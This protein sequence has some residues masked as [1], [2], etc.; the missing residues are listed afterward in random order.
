MR[1]FNFFF[2]F[3]QKNAFSSPHL[4]HSMPQGA[5]KL[6]FLLQNPD[7]FASVSFSGLEEDPIPC[8][9]VVDGIGPCL[10]LQA[11]APVLDDGG[12]VLACEPF[13]HSMC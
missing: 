2:P 13:I 8:I 10:C 7:C 1:L 12:A 9:R 5:K 3:T 4:K 6:F 11:H